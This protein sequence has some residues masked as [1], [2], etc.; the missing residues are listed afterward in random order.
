MNAHPHRQRLTPRP[1][2]DPALGI[3][4]MLEDRIRHLEATAD[5]VQGLEQRAES[6]EREVRA[7]HS[8]I[9]DLEQFVGRSTSPPETYANSVGSSD[10]KHTPSHPEVLS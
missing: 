3:L 1:A 10:S 6:L 9:D 2:S 8:R 5:Y 7:L 4:T